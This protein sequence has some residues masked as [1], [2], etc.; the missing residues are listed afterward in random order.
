MNS[1]DEATSYDKEKKAIISK[2]EKQVFEHLIMK[3]SAR[4]IIK[5]FLTKTRKL[6]LFNMYKNSMEE[7]KKYNYKSNY[8][9]DMFGRDVEDGLNKYIGQL[10]KVKLK[11]R[12]IIVLG[13]RVKNRWTSNSD[14]DLTF[15]ADNL[16]DK[17]N[18]IVSRR[19][20]YSKINKILSDTFFMGIE[21]SLCYSSKEFIAKLN[22][23]DIHTLDA[24]LYG[25]VIYDDGFWI[26]VEREYAQI[27]KK[28]RLDPN[29]LKEK[30]L[31]V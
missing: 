28:Y 1:Y 9:Y 23:F 31:L 4:K 7:I 6:V 27:V 5:N 25:K 15:V 2:I 20:Y 8:G 10:D 18:N 17:G 22:D 21:P 14:V 19:I 29:I 13:S 3:N 12:T 26:S 11:I 16:P 24:I 30:I